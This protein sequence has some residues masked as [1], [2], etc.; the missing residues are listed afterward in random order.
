MAAYRFAE[1]Q[2]EAQ[3]PPPACSEECIWYERRLNSL[4]CANRHKN[5]CRHHRR[6][7]FRSQERE[8]EATLS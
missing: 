7:I 1:L 5:I 6:D 8:A 2:L 3:E 4:A